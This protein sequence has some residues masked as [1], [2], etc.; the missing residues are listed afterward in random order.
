ML[1]TLNLYSRG[2]SGLIVKSCP[3]L[4]TQ[5]TVAH[6]APL[7]NPFCQDFPGKNNGIGCH[8]LL[9]RIFPTHN[10]TRVSCI[11]GQILYHWATR[12]SQFI[13]LVL[14]AQ[15]CPTLCNPMDC[16]LPGSS[17]HGISQAR[18]LKWVAVPFSKGSSWYRDWTR[19]SCIADRFFTMW[20]IKETSIYIVLY[21]NY[22]NKTGKK[23]KIKI[24]ISAKEY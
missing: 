6:Q 14:V 20:T 4:V 3:T 13:Q 2:G 24:F 19:I 11:G 21:V 8:F 1:Y 15:S 5:W 9:Y 16:S 12:N 10:W 18:I 7:L 23:I 22:I 17:V